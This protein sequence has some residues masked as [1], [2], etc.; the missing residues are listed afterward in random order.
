[1]GMRLRVT[2]EDF[3]MLDCFYTVFPELMERYLHLH[4]WHLYSR[5]FVLLIEPVFG[6]LKRERKIIKMTYSIRISFEQRN[7]L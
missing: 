6:H 5:H 3:H 1:M 7:L 4:S 2:Q